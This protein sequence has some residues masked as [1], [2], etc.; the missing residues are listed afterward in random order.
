MKINSKGVLEFDFKLSVAFPFCVQY[1][2]LNSAAVV[3][4]T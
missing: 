3:L 1:I 2:D 4:C